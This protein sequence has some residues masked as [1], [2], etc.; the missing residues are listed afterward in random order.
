MKLSEAIRLGAMST[1][2]TTDHR[3]YGRDDHGRICATCAIGAAAHAVGATELGTYSFGLITGDFS[4]L[5]K[6]FPLLNLTIQAWP[7]GVRPRVA[8]W[9]VGQ[10]MNVLF[11][12]E[13]WTRE[14]IADWVES[15][16]LAQTTPAESRE[17]VSTEQETASPA[18]SYAQK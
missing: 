7:H 3:F 18:V 10:Q 12:F 11:E 1:K 4:P 6:I 16:E 2:A 17:A 13:H 8:D 5:A 9:T 15:I 14:R